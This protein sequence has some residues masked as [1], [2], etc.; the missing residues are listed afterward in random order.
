[1]DTIFETL[2]MNNKYKPGSHNRLIRE[3]VKYRLELVRVQESKWDKDGSEQADHIFFFCGKR[4]EDHQLQTGFLVH[5]ITIWD[6]RKV[7]S[8][9]L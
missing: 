2:D 6:I 8:Y 3:S 9:N 1:M 7:A 4:S 5:K